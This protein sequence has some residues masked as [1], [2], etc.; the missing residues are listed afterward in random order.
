MEMTRPPSFPSRSRV[1]FFR[2]ITS[3]PASEGIVLIGCTGRM[4][5]KGNRRTHALSSCTTRQPVTFLLVGQGHA[6]N[7]WR[8]SA[9]DSANST[10][11]KVTGPLPSALTELFKPPS[12]LARRAVAPPGTQGSRAIDLN[13]ATSAI[14]APLRRLTPTEAGAMKDRVGSNVLPKIASESQRVQ[15]E[16]PPVMIPPRSR[17]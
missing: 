1:G 14:A 3:T 9:L 6:I 4:A 13:G 16:D 8:T 2:N 11:S 15:H 10:R 7:S 12:C 5:A 17:M